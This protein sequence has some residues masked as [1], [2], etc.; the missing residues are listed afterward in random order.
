M[1]KP[2][3][4]S[5][6]LD[7]QGMESA[8]REIEVLAFCKWKEAGCPDNSAFNFWVEAEMEWIEYRYVP[9]RYPS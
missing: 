5:L 8:R 9:D 3:L 1:K 6:P 2:S 4:E 7:A